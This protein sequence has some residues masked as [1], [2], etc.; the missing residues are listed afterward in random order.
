[1]SIGRLKFYDHHGLPVSTSWSN[2]VAK[3]SMYVFEVD[4]CPKIALT[5]DES[6]TRA[7]RMVYDVSDPLKTI[8]YF[9]AF[10][11]LVDKIE[12]DLSGLPFDEKVQF[13]CFNSQGET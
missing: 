6:G 4:G 8:E 9:P 7:R 3:S 11:D 10:R 5:T 2:P 13:M 1:M 12:V